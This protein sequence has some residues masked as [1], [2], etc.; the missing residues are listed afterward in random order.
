MMEQ[1][2]TGSRKMRGAFTMMELILVLVIAGAAAYLIYSSFK[3]T[4][5][6]E[7]AR[8]EGVRITS[9][10]GA[11]ENIKSFNAGAYP[12]SSEKA[13]SQ[14]PQ[15]QRELGGAQGTTDI[16]SWTYSC[17][18]G[19]DSTPTI[20]TSKYENA[21]VANMVADRVRGNLAPWTAR[22]NGTQITLTRPHSVCK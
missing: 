20:K 16:S 11:L 1:K 12:A 17:T 3:K 21:D 22:V 2:K 15:I 5:A 7:T 19:T 6:G 4:K 9:V 14:L 18:A 8:N 13:I 10:V